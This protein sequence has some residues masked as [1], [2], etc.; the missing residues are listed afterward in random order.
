MLKRLL[1][2][3]RAPLLLIDQQQR[4][5]QVNTAL[6][7]ALGVTATHVTGQPCCHLDAHP[8]ADCRHRRFFRDLEP[9]VESREMR[10]PEDTLRVAR[11][12]GFPM[13]DAQGGL[14]LGEVLHLFGQAQGSGTIVGVSKTLRQLLSYLEQ[15]AATDAAV[16]LW[17]ETGSGKELAA[18]YIHRHSARAAGPFVVVDCTVLNE[19]LF[20]SELFGHVKGAFT[21]AVA[22]KTG[23]MELADG[24]TLF[25]D[26]I[27]ELPL[28][29]QP[30]LLRALE[31]GGY[32]PVGATNMRHANVRVI[33]ATHRDLSAMAQ[34]GEFRQD[35]YYRLAVLPV[36]IPPLRERREDIPALAEHLLE[37]MRVADARPYRLRPDALRRLLEYDFPGN[38]RELRNLLHL[39]AALSMDGEIGA[40]AIRPSPVPAAR[41][42]DDSSPRAAL[43]PADPRLSPIEAAEARYILELL[44]RHRGSRKDVAASMAIS[45]RTLYRKLNRYGLNRSQLEQP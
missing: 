19:D 30:K 39:G 28:S 1:L 10:G 41:A 45:E 27:G 34:R 2:A 42:G 44:Q 5:V 38:V 31:T 14:Y 22:A 36:T 13:M 40:D 6:V 25:L 21:G 29:Q 35:L 4:I 11:V 32:R 23:L 3:Q 37:E 9:Y 12:Q 15:A 18:E 17:G 7:N 24:G 33:S 20:E 43:P 8:A 16:L 26:E